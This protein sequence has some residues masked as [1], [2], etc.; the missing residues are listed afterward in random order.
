MLVE[1]TYFGLTNIDLAFW[2]MIGTWLASIGTI[3]AVITSLYLA[4]KNDKINL[5]VTSDIV[6][7][8]GY[9]KNY[10]EDSD[11][12]I[13][14]EIVNNGNKPVTIQNVGWQM[15][16]GKAF[17]VPFNPNPLT[18]QLPKMINYGE[19]A[20][21]AIEVSAVKNIWIPDFIRDGVKKQ[22]VNKWKICIHISTGEKITVK[23]NKKIIELI[24]NNL[25][26]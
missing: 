17:V 3:A 16:K 11:K 20:R 19:V 24:Q 14:I 21:W 15:T 23:P 6:F 4:R 8:F 7:L 1:T 9:S 10:E 26:S 12:Y 22:D 25:P 5:L 13:N 18:T 2:S